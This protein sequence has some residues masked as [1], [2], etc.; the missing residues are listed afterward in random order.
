MKPTNWIPKTSRQRGMALITVVAM[1]ALATVLM[2]ALFTTTENEYK[3]TQGYAAGQSARLLGDAATNIV[4]GQL[5]KAAIQASSSGPRTIHATQPGAARKYNATGEFVAG[6]KLYSDPLMEVVKAGATG[7]KEFAGSVPPKDWD[8]KPAQYVDLNEPA[9]RATAGAVGSAAVTKVF[10]PIVD[11]RS[12]TTNDPAKAKFSVEGFSYDTKPAY[13]SSASLDDIDG[14]ITP[15]IA[16]DKPD[17]QRLPMPVAW[18]YILQDGTL[19]TLDNNKAFVPASGGTA[20]SAANP[21]TGRI[22][23]WADDE[24]CKVNVNTASEP[25]FWGVPRFFHDRDREWAEKPGVAREYQ[26]YPGHPATVALS[27]ILYP[28]PLDDPARDLT[29]L[30]GKTGA[31]RQRVIDIKEAI[32]RMIPKVNEGGSQSGTNVFDTDTLAADAAE[33]RSNKVSLV[34]STKERLFA[35]LDEMLFSDPTSATPL[36]ANKL[37]TENSI[38]DS[39]GNVIFDASALE[40]SRFFLTAQS[41]APEFSILGLP[42]IAM[43][44]ISARTEAGY[45]TPYDQLI[46]FCSTFKPSDTSSGPA[47]TNNYYFQRQKAH[48]SG[49]DISIPRNMKLMEYLLKV[50]KTN[51]PSTGVSGDSKSFEKKY[52]GDNAHQILLEIFDY[53]RSTN[54]YDDILSDNNQSPAPATRTDRQVYEQAPT[55]YFSYTNPLMKRNRTTDDSNLT[56][57]AQV[58]EDNGWPGH[59]Q[60]TPSIAGKNPDSGGGSKLWTGE[61]KTYLG[62]GRSFTIS[63]FGLQLICT[64]D[65][66]PDAGSYVGP[67]GV[68]SGGGTAERIDILPENKYVFD[69]VLTAYPG[70]KFPAGTTKCYWYSNFPPNPSADPAR[71]DTLRKKYGVEPSIPTPSPDPRNP[72]FHPGCNPMNWNCTLEENKPLDANQKRVQAMINLE[73]FCP[74]EGWTLIHPEFTIVLSGK[75]ISKITVDGTSIFATGDSVVV[76]SRNNVYTPNSVNRTGGVSPPRSLYQGYACNQ[77]GK[78][79]ADTGYQNE[80]D[81]SIHSKMLNCDLLSN[82]FTVDRTK[83]IEIKFPDGD[84]LEIQLYDTHDWQ[85]KKPYQTMKVNLARNPGDTSIKVPVPDLAGG[86]ATNRKTGYTNGKRYDN[87]AIQAPRYWAYHDGGALGRYVFSSGKYQVGWGNV[88]TTKTTNSTAPADASK[89]VNP[90]GDRCRGRLFAL[91]GYNPVIGSDVVRTM[92]PA[93]GDYRIIAATQAVPTSMWVPHR[94]WDQADK[95][96]MHN[97]SSHTG[98]SEGGV[99]LGGVKGD[100][101][102]S[103]AKQFITSPDMT[104]RYVNDKVPDM[105][106]DDVALGA[107]NSFLDYDNGV[108]TTRDGAYINKPDEGNFSILYFNRQMNPPNGPTVLNKVRNAYF[109]ASWEMEPDK[110]KDPLTGKLD[111]AFF[112]PN[113]MISSPVMFGSLPTAVHDNPGK[114]NGYSGSGRPWQ[115]L[116]FRPHAYNSGDKYPVSAVHPGAQ[117]PPDHYILDMFNMPVVEPYAE[118]EPL[119]QAGKI[120]VNYQILPF[121]YIK[122]ATGM[123]AA[124]KGEM[125]TAIPLTA[126]AGTEGTPV[127]KDTN[128][129]GTAHYKSTQNSDKY[130]F[131]YKFWS[132]TDSNDPSFWH[133]RVNVKETLK[134][135]DERFNFDKSL[136]STPNRGGLFRSASQI[137]EVHLIPSKGDGGSSGPSG[138]TSSDRE[139]KMGK[140]WEDHALTGDNTR[141]RPYSNIYAHLTTRSNTFRVHIRAQ[142][143]KKARS[144]AADHFDPAADQVLSEYRGSTLIERFI[145]PNDTTNALPDYADGSDPLSKP[146]LDSYYKFRVVETKKFAP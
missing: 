139:Q 146:S 82:F 5:Q 100:G 129:D 26:R 47:S 120:N 29:D 140:F 101:S 93:L 31:A 4:I 105:P 102:F 99:D 108:G 87:A 43:W 81:G 73:L 45:K 94:F 77:F 133:S 41:R 16:K 115:T 54:L 8:T 35:S 90:L 10:F 56:V 113:R 30:F 22:A 125:I 27:S 85:N 117:N 9:V 1:L 19:G 128:W 49:F 76:K 59:G 134:Q 114:L 145:D 36:D 46:A 91:N 103:G 15:T 107:L 32:Y 57:P 64:G 119:S 97:F 18:L 53:I 58:V 21:I 122:R 60:V 123:W 7:E 72:N 67:G 13:S 112:T 96:V 135:L 62:F 39:S 104:K 20:A 14:I 38:K 2:L 78:M 50:M 79:P 61:S 42:K 138:M 95:K 70:V 116:L 111:N 51:L 131:P 12:F 106:R 84:G 89:P 98:N 33:I 118:S 86:A 40:R 37:R 28:N 88:V 132:D 74:A 124:M 126:A 80:A 141:E 63:E 110:H 127:M 52:G 23:F 44:P 136:A 68:I 71:G 92:I 6:Y 130:P 121:T 109:T 3:S 48:D 137:C 65:G 24:S 143:I 25:T 66:Q 83:P 75:Y 142:V 69:T 144:S 55:Q 17:N 11:P 34:D